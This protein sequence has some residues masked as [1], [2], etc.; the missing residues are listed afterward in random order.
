MLFCIHALNFTD[1]TGCKDITEYCCWEQMQ[2]ICLGHVGGTGLIKP[3]IY[4]FAL[5]LVFPNQI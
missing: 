1:M 3:T 2:I 4:I 5:F